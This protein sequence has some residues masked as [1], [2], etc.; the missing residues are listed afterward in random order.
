PRS[1]KTPE[2][3]QMPATEIAVRIELRES[4]GLIRQ[5]S[6]G[7]HRLADGHP[8]RLEIPKERLHPTPVHG[9]HR[10]CSHFSSS[11]T[12]LSVPPRLISSRIRFS[13]SRTS[14]ARFAISTASSRAT[15]IRPDSSPTIQSPERTF[16]PP[17]SLSLPISP[18]P[19]GS[20]ACGP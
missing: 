3:Y 19:F 14:S 8:A 9:P 15:T 18:S 1:P 20:P 6:E 5:V 11:R 7:I 2:Q 12:E 4:E 16:C 13:R 10:I 17:H